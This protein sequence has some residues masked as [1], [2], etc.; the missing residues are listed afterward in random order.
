MEG[1][2]KGMI[3]PAV[4]VKVRLSSDKKLAVGQ[5]IIYDT[6][7]ENQGGAYSLNSGTFRVQVDGTYIFAVK[8]CSYGSGWDEVAIVKGGKVIAKALSLDWNCGADVT[9]VYAQAGSKVWVKYSAGTHGNQRAAHW[10]SFS[11]VL[12]A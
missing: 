8:T 2:L 12:V 7:L 4:V 5:R 10:C 6:I 1:I 3:K 11:A 9:A